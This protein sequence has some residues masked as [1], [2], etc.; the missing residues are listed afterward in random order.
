MLPAVR[1]IGDTDLVKIEPLGPSLFLDGG[2]CEPNDA[3]RGR[4]RRLHVLE[5]GRTKVVP[6]LDQ[7]QRLECPRIKPLLNPGIVRDDNHGVWW[8]GRP[9]NVAEPRPVRCASS[10]PRLNLSLNTLKDLVLES[11]E[12]SAFAR[13]DD[14]DGSTELRYVIDH[15]IDDLVSREREPFERY[16][17]PGGCQT[18]DGPCQLMD[19]F[20]VVSC[21]GCEL[22]NDN[23]W[24]PELNRDRPRLA[25]QGLE[26]SAA[27]TPVP[28]DICVNGDCTDV[29]GLNLVD[30]LAHRV[31][32]AKDDPRCSHRLAPT[33]TPRLP[34]LQARQN[35]WRGQLVFLMEEDPSGDAGSSANDEPRQQDWLK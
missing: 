20:V 25:C 24:Q 26:L 29:V 8:I 18:F 10:H 1:E 3:F 30:L 27:V 28:E 33:S 6:S 32:H 9:N 35:D 21:V 5:E 31:S 22:P 19:F 4:C 11:L 12:C 15:V 17:Q 14:P 34:S 2:S 13:R 16:L 23:L 7:W